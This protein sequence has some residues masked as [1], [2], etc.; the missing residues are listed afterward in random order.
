[1]THGRVILTIGVYGWTATTFAAALATA[2]VDVLVDIRARR[3]VRGQEYAFANSTR[4]QGMLE[5]RGIA[6][7]HVTE[8]APSSEVRAIQRSRD[9]VEG[10]GKRRR[11]GLDPA[12]VQAY[13]EQILGTADI[14][15]LTARL[16]AWSRPCLLCVE[17]S[18][19][20]CHRS[21]AADALLTSDRIGVEHLLP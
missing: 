21:L 17:A 9:A 4:L 7:L 16:S 6:Y 8:L 5:E 12:F 1:M 3:G 19:E 10:A 2:G 14:V 20:A 13:E 11:S 18:P 15:Q